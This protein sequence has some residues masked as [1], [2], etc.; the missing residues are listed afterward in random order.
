MACREFVLDPNETWAHRIFLAKLLSGELGRATSIWSELVAAA[1]D[2]VSSRIKADVLH[3]CPDSTRIGRS[4]L[5]LL[6]QVNA[7][8]NLEDQIRGID[9]GCVCSLPPSTANF[10]R[11]PGKRKVAVGRARTGARDATSST[12]PR[13]AGRMHEVSVRPGS[14]SAILGSVRSRKFILPG[15]RGRVCGCRIGNRTW[16]T[17]RS[18]RVGGQWEEKQRHSFRDSARTLTHGVACRWRSVGSRRIRMPRRRTGAGPSAIA[19]SRAPAFH[20]RNPGAFARPRA[21]GSAFRKTCPKYVALRG[22]ENR[23]I[24]SGIGTGLQSGFKRSSIRRDR[25]QV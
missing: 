18:H 19:T 1:L 25:P 6:R 15:R 8:G 7:N 3:F 21:V 4:E 17:K 10:D 16:G 14:Q 24:M 20:V 13:D 2:A 12:L 5:E 9:G 22:F 11:D 23:P